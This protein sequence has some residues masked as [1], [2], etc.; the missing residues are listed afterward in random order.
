M[1][2][3]DP[4]RT[5]ALTPDMHPNFQRIP[6]S[7]DLRAPSVYPL[8]S[9]LRHKTEHL[10]VKRTLSVSK[11][12]RAMLLMTQQQL[13]VVSSRFGSKAPARGEEGK[14]HLS[15]SRVII[16]SEEQLRRNTSPP[17]LIASV[18]VQPPVAEDS[19][20]ARSFA[21]KPLCSTQRVALAQRCARIPTALTNPP[22]PL[23][24]R[25]CLP[26]Q[27]RPTEIIID[28]A[29]CS[30]VWEQCGGI[31]WDGPT[32]CKSPDTCVNRG[33]YYSQCVPY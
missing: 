31:G 15:I 22:P 2:H 29:N 24:T 11:S 27:C 16:T 4:I 26:Q 5:F 8:S 32:C 14:V 6:S 9:K 20:A 18:S 21:L 28:E 13:A 12:E 30:N 7:L 25:K 17:E 23:P 19:L 33:D 3:P 1:A 10:Y